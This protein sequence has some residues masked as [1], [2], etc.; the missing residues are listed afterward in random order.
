M[1]NGKG[2]DV[3]SI[4]EML[5]D[6]IP[7]GEPD[8]YIRHAG[9]A[10]A[11]FAAAAAKNGLDA[12]MCCSVGDDDFGRYLY[13]TLSLLG[14]SAPNTVMCKN[15][16]TTMS[17][18]SLDE[19]GERSFTFARCPGA[20]MFL[21]E[22]MVDDD[23]V[24]A[25]RLVHAGSF[26]L[27]ES[28][29]REA[30]LK[31]MRLAHEAGHLVSFDVNYRDTVWHGQRS[32]CARRVAEAA[33]YIDILKISDEEADLIGGEESIPAFMKRYDI[34]VVAETLGDKGSECYFAGNVITT[35]SR[36]VKAVDTTGAGDAFFGAFM[37]S[38]LIEG[39]DTKEKLM[40]DAILR[41]AKYGNISASICVSGYGGIS[42]IPTRDEILSAMGE[43]KK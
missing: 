32:D 36:H 1:K 19:H 31:A 9:G 43:T 7:G 2:L 3:Y 6:F 5:I 42:S 24:L 28:P 15:A 4:G 33:P 10:P 12:A 26:S 11:N 34:S 29:A 22:D 35:P 20:D 27:S 41:A 38:L 16:V 8:S 23:E 13:K 40:P 37:S 17:F 25:S 21:S 39:A 18:I 30:T 14:V